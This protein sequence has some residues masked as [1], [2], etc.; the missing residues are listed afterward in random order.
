MAA[1]VAQLENKTHTRLAKKSA[2]Q[3]TANGSTP[4]TSKAKPLETQE[5]PTPSS[6]AQTSR[7]QEKYSYRDAG[8]DSSSS[9]NEDYR[10]KCAGKTDKDSVSAKSSERET[11]EA[12]DI[13]STEEESEESGS[14]DRTQDS[15]LERITEEG[16]ST[17]ATNTSHTSPDRGF[18]PIFDTI[19]VILRRRPVN[20][21]HST[22]AR[23]SLGRLPS[24]MT[25]K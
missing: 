15:V 17:I 12:D 23:N 14:E 1:A 19:S 11:S 6:V 13:S 8:N 22:R 21:I 7:T 2:P 20:S 16:Q 4:M 9:D 10:R 25:Q 3:K 18:Y 24:P 5:K